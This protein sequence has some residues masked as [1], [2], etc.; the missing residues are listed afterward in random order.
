MPTSTSAPTTS[1]LAGP[2]VLAWLRPLV[3]LGAL[4]PALVLLYG[5]FTNGL[6]P[7]PAEALL[8]GTGEWGARLLI[9]TLLISPLRSLTGW[10]LVIKLRRMLGL[11]VFFYACLHLLIFVQFD[12]GWSAAR[13]WEELLERPYISVG[14]AA[15]L[16]LLP[17]AITSSRGM[18][19]RLRRN[20]Q[21][22]HRLVYAVAMLVSLHLVW[23]A[24]SDIGEAVFYSGLFA[25]LLGWRVLDRWRKRRVVQA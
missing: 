5:A 20:W 1:P 24:R 3:F 18:Q 10:S 19:R 11:F 9:A 14:F 7:D 21:R 8:H 16:L 22:L 23:Q 13:V 2:A 15:W 25:V 17:L 6:G 12:L 4:A